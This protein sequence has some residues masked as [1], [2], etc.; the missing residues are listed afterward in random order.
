MTRRYLVFVALVALASRGSAQDG[1]R[2][3]IDRFGYRLGYIGQTV[4]A[5]AGVLDASLRP[6]PNATIVWR[7]DQPA[8]AT[9]SPRGVVQ[10]RAVGYTRL[11]AV[12]GRD[13]ASAVILVMVPDNRGKSDSIRVEFGQRQ[14]KLALRDSAA[15]PV[16]ALTDTPRV[17]VLP[18]QVASVRRDTVKPLARDTSR[19]EVPGVPPKSS[20][21]ATTPR[22]QQQRARAVRDSVAA[23]ADLR[24][25][26]RLAGR[27][28]TVTANA[29]HT[30]HSARLTRRISESRAGLLAGGTASLAPT[31]RWLASG[32]FRV[33]TLTGGETSD[34]DLKVTEATGQLTYWTT[35]WLGLRGGY[36]LRSESTDL[37]LHRWQ[38]VNITALSRF[39]FREGAITSVTALSLLPWGTFS[40][41][42]D[43]AG[44]PVAPRTTSLALETGLEFHLGMLRAGIMHSSEQFVFPALNGSARR[45]RFSSLRIRLGIETGPRN[46]PI[47]RR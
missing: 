15:A 19:A 13:S 33:G 20:G 28:I 42:L 10:A 16:A 24:A 8:I 34:G 22:Q 4:S 9:V 47:S 40:G 11:W 26:R 21:V 35:R 30:T 45:D 25:A 23:A 31:A 12:A 46:Q 5:N 32:D 3:V 39:A 29:S 17:G 1:R 41:H 18:V 7:T 43:N 27:L 37:V 2:V 36:T 38:F 6:V 44:R 14:T